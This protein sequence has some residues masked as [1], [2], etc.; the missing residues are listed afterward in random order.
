MKLCL[1]DVNVFLDLMNVSDGLHKLQLSKVY[2][3]YYKVYVS[4]NL[5][6]QEREIPDLPPAKPTLTKVLPQERKTLKMKRN[7]N[8]SS[9]ILWIDKTTAV[10]NRGAEQVEA[11]LW[12]ELKKLKGE[13]FLKPNVAWNLVW[14]NY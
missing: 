4:D 2:Q 1:N 10:R 8:S 6:I 12:E 9:P 14:N 11:I 5:E 7:S 13:E 3:I